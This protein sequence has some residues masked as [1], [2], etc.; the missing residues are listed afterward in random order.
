MKIS[1]T[2][3]SI[4][5][6]V[7]RKFSERWQGYHP[8]LLPIDSVDSG[9]D[10]GFI[11]LTPTVMRETDLN[12]NAYGISSSCQY[13]EAAMKFLN[14]MFSDPKVVNL[15]CYGIEGEHYQVIDHEKGIIDY[16][17]GVT[18]R[19]STYSQFRTY[20]WGEPASCICLKGF[21]EDVWEQEIQYNDTAPRSLA[22]GFQFNPEPVQEGI[23]GLP[24]CHVP[25]SAPP[26]RTGR[27]C[28]ILTGRNDQAA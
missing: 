18:R 7:H 20:H 21:P 11:P 24:V 13:P 3:P 6:S 23:W 25:V 22:N 28:G 8:A 12:G 2:V 10:I 16:A 26:G 4:I 14:L 15:L 27:T 5:L 9:E 17:D 19:T 1:R